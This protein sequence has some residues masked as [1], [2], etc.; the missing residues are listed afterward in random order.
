[1]L[2]LERHGLGK[3]LKKESRNGSCSV[4][5]LAL[6]QRTL[7]AM[8]C[9]PAWIL[10]RQAVGVHEP[11][12]YVRYADMTSVTRG[13]VGKEKARRSGL[14]AAQSLS[15]LLATCCTETSQS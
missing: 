6:S 7:H 8:P 13:S 2:S 14:V 4:T 10:V 11:S 3:G 5:R 1:V 12:A 15:G 9:G